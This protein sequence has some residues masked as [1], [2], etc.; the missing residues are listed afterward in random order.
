MHG[1]S[2]TGVDSRIESHNATEHRLNNLAR[3][4]VERLGH[5]RMISSESFLANKGSSEKC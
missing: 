3:A 1:D 2:A 5:I 4:V